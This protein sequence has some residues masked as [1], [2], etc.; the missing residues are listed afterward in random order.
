MVKRQDIL[1]AL[2]ILPAV[3]PLAPVQKEGYLKRL[4]EDT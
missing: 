3:T 2:H 1:I 4:A